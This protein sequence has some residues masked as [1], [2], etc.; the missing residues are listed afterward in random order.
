MA[1]AECPKCGAKIVQI[2]VNFV[3]EGE[4]RCIDLKGTKYLNPAEVSSPGIQWCPSLSDAAP[5]EW[6]LLSPGSRQAVL[7]EINRVKKK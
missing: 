4:E 7:N 3:S 1:T 5:D 2:G 6:M